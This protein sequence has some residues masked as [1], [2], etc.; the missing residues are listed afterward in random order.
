M[1]WIK[2]L[3]RRQ[4]AKKKGKMEARANTLGPMSWKGPSTI[5]RRDRANGALIN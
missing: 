2:G 5:L 3:E 1:W 4:A